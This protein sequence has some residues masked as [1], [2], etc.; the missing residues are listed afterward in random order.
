MSGESVEAFR[1]E[2]CKRISPVHW[3]FDTD[4]GLTLDDDDETVVCGVCGHEYSCRAAVSVFVIA[5][6]RLRQLLEN[7]RKEIACLIASLKS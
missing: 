6:A 3:W 5:A 1:C 7:S 4:I 2:H